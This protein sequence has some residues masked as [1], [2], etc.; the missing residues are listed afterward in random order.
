MLTV[1]VAF[2]L[3]L[4]SSFAPFWKRMCSLFLPLSFTCIHLCSSQLWRKSG[5]HAYTLLMLRQ[6]PVW[7]P[8]LLPFYVQDKTQWG[9]VSECEYV[10]I[11]LSVW[12]LV[13]SYP[14]AHACTHA[15]GWVL[16]WKRMQASSVGHKPT[17]LQEVKE[18]VISPSA[19]CNM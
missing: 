10:P 6:P 15:L 7:T 2:C 4:I 17:S 3:F 9:D 1:S 14:K 5:L 8:I 19:S 12:A 13:F 18:T 16:E 11:Y